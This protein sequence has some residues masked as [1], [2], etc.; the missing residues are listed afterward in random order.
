M[1]G[2]SYGWTQGIVATKSPAED[3]D[4]NSFANN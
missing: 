4:Y 3:S 1:P 2:A